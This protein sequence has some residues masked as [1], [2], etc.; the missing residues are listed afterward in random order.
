MVSALYEAAIK[1]NSDSFFS[2][3]LVCH[4]QVRP[5]WRSLSRVT[6][7]SVRLRPTV[8]WWPLAAYATR[9]IE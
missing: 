2:Y 3:L 1:G 6:D 8:D 7:P 4:W 5:E 9:Y